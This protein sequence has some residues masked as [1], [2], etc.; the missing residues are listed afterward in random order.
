MHCIIGMNKKMRWMISVATGI[1]ALPAGYA[2]N[3]LVTS[4][5]QIGTL[6]ALTNALALVY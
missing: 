4:S 2:A 5:T 6:L 1:A 3:L